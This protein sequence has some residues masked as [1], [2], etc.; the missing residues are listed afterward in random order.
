MD[1][2]KLK[3]VWIGLSSI[4]VTAII[5]YWGWFYVSFNG[6]PWKKYVIANELK[7]HVEQKYNIETTI[8]ER[9]YTFKKP[10]YGVRLSEKGKNE[11]FT[12][13]ADKVGD[14]LLDSYLQHVWASQ[15]NED[16]QPIVE[17]HMTNVHKHTAHPSSHIEYNYTGVIPLYKD[18]NE[19]LQYHILL[20]KVDE[21]VTLTQLFHVIDEMKKKD[22]RNVHLY[23][24]SQTLPPKASFKT[25]DIPGN[26]LD[27]IKTK[28]DILKY[29]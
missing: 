19:Q 2:I 7:E 20:K 8:E 23:V 14:E 29:R 16:M 10:S 25:L 15:I 11:T 24:G 9:Y 18:V 13:T 3:W 5:L 26:E 27:N 22:I 6:L 12:F 21:E 17:K 28:E 4:F 1:K